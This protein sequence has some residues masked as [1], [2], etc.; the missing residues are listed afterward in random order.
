MMHATAGRSPARLSP[1]AL[2]S[3]DTGVDQEG[4]SGPFA[5]LSRVPTGPVIRRKCAT[6]ERD[7]EASTAVSPKLAVGAIDDPAEREADAIADR[8]MAGNA[9]APAALRSPTASAAPLAR[10]KPAGGTMPVIGP[11]AS[12]LGSL[13]GGKPMPASDRAF[14]EPRMGQDLSHVRLHDDPAAAAAAAGMGARAFTIGSDI[15]MGRGQY[16]SN[17]T[18][19]HLL[20]HELAHVQQNDGVVRMARLEIVDANFVG[21]LSANQRRAAAS[22]GITCGGTNIGTFQAMPIYYRSAS[23]PNA[24][25]TRAGSEGINTQLHFIRNGS[26]IPATNACASCGSYKVIQTVTTNASLRSNGAGEYVDNNEQS[27][28]YYTDVFQS[29]GSIHTIDPR[30]ADA[31]HEV[32]TTTSIYDN[33]NR[34]DAYLRGRGIRDMNWQAEA[35]VTCVK[36]GTSSTGDPDRVLGCVNYG[37]SRPWL[38]PSDSHGDVVISGPT[39]RATPSAGFQRILRND[40]TT[41]SYRFTV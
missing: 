24:T 11:A 6:C 18:A 5:S 28:P 7:D 9:A 10:A 23:S 4:G 34:P 13:G 1:K 38:S 16:G 17:H 36:S 21:P 2:G 35:C 22:C 40:P 41:S 27:T 20:A 29:G 8:V 3:L 26:A 32:D 37:F 12:A 39:C 33:P 19:R 25:S 31:G 30:F 15:V 14:F